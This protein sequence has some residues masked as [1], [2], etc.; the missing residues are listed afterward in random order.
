MGEYE[1]GDIPARLKRLPKLAAPD[2]FADHLRKQ[3][4][5]HPRPGRFS[6]WFFRPVPVALVVAGG[7]FVVAVFVAGPN[8]SVTPLVPQN[9]PIPAPSE[10]QIEHISGKNSSE[11][12]ELPT[13]ST[14]DTL[15]ADSTSI[16]GKDVNT[17]KMP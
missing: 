10:R 3:T 8:L 14:P 4:W 12:R 15:T 9:N 7:A 2:Q 17:S 13:R 1:Q 5:S 16:F 6:G 11:R